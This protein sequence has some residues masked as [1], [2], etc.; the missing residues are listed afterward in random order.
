[1][2]LKRIRF[3]A[4]VATLVLF[5]AFVMSERAEADA[6][7]PTAPMPGAAGAPGSDAPAGDEAAHETEGTAG[8][9]NEREVEEPTTEREDPTERDA[10]AGSEGAATEPLAAILP[11]QAV[12]AEPLLAQPEAREV[13]VPSEVNAVNEASA[14]D[15]PERRDFLRRLRSTAENVERLRSSEP[16][17]VRTE[18][19][20][21][22]LTNV[23]PLTR[24]E[25]PVLA[26]P[27]L[28]VIPAAPAP[29]AESPPSSEEQA[30]ETLTTKAPEE[31]EG[32]WH[33]VWVL[34]GVATVLL[35]PIGVLLTR[36]TRSS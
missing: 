19:D 3:T 30:T 9:A 6:G 21:T 22:V 28:A 26:R 8:A 29:L 13:N 25:E 11:E 20:V 1:M 15:V 5:C 7:A 35:V 33:W 32:Q 31:A 14:N 10:P 17:L 2:A 4:C 12:I 34:A 27:V 23:A 24:A 36:A 16:T 18:G